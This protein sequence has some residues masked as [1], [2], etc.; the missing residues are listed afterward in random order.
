MIKDHMPT[1]RV[2]TR[3]LG[4]C[5]YLA[6]AEAAQGLSVFQKLSE[7]GAAT[8]LP[9][10]ELAMLES[11]DAKPTIKS[12]PVVL[13]YRFDPRQDNPK[14]VIDSSTG[15]LVTP[16]SV[17]WPYNG[18]IVKVE[19]VVTPGKLTFNPSTGRCYLKEPKFYNAALV[20]DELPEC[21][22]FGNQEVRRI[23]KGWQITTSW[24]ERQS[25]AF[26]QGLWLEY[27]PG[28][29]CMLRCSDDNFGDYTVFYTKGRYPDL[30]EE[31]L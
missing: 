12:F 9:N 14:P 17:A 5:L 15:K 6:S 31:I 21:L 8:I 30:I 24:G 25:C 7:H 26:G 3:A 1:I 28:N 27:A 18:A 29:V 4:G 13:S 22:D 23:L 16:T 11:R 10:G 20:S 19:N 2:G